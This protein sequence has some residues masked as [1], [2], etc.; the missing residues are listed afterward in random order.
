[1]PSQGINGQQVSQFVE[2]AGQ[3]TLDR[4][5]VSVQIKQGCPQHQGPGAHFSP[6]PAQ[7]GHWVSI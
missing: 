6:F 3:Q 7:G 1:M 5:P 2:G 4:H